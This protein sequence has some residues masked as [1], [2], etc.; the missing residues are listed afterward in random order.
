MKKVK[1]GIIGF[2]K[3]GSHYVRR[4]LETDICKNVE[5]IAIAENNQTRLNWAK[6][7][8]SGVALFD[9]AIK[10]I[11][12]FNEE[13]KKEY[14]ADALPTVSNILESYQIR[15]EDCLECNFDENL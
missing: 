9:D 7:H 12:A 2:G 4:F 14:D 15:I 6:E 11:S 3:H 13:V 8:L 1:V 5:L 10:I